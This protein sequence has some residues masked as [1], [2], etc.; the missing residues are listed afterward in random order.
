M[1][2]YQINAF[3]FTFTLD[4]KEVVSLAMVLVAHQGILLKVLLMEDYLQ[5]ELMEEAQLV[6]DDLVVIHPIM[7]EAF[8]LVD[9]LLLLNFQDDLGHKDLRGLRNLKDNPDPKDHKGFLEEDLIIQTLLSIQQ[10]YKLL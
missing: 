5:I 3:T 6:E 8:L 7:I 9:A 2:L 1:G 10:A 4:S